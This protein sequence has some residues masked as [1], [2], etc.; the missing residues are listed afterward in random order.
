MTDLLMP[1]DGL[2][3]TS[4]LPAIDTLLKWPG[5]KTR[6]LSRILLDQ[7]RFSGR[8]V[9]P[10]VG[11][12][13]VALAHARHREVRANDTSPDLIS[14]YDSLKRGDAAVTRSL[15]SMAE[16]WSTWCGRSVA[17]EKLVA[18]YEAGAEDRFDLSLLL[19]E[20]ATNASPFPAF[21]HAYNTLLLTEVPKKL[22]RIRA[23]EHARHQLSEKDLD[24][25]VEG[26][27]RA[28]WYLAVRKRYND[29]RRQGLSTPERTVL[30]FFLRE[31][32][33]AAMFRF[34][35]SGTFN[36]PYGGVSYNGKDLLSKAAAM[37]APATVEALSGCTFD[38]QDFEV[39]LEDIAPTADDLVFLDPP[40][41][42]TFAHYD[43]RPFG[44]D[45]HR[46][47]SD[48]IDRCEAPVQLVIKD[49]P[50]VR[51]V[52]LRPGRRAVAVDKTYAWTIKSRNDRAASHL[53]ITT[54]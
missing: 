11:G 38:N 16:T 48:R 4:S 44:L 31:L 30:F 42:S 2:P 34:S 25:N 15:L 21:N 45:D 51:E 19:G 49:T 13:S 27:F 39:F 33:Y 26:A 24:S 17:A 43:D 41:D 36:V 23:V 7:P 35:A 54:Y 20:G 3:G 53:H 50:A 5:G 6:E 22:A 14:L 9:D 52:Y 12:G 32:C 8:L 46:R 40:Y 37:T 47:L 29:L 1:L 18:A 10:F 28:V